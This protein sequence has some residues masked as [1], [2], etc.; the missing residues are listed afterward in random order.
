MS[1]MWPMFIPVVA[2]VLLAVAVA[3]DAATLVPP[4]RGH[5]GITYLGLVTSLLAVAGLLIIALD[6]ALGHIR[7]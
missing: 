2:V 7:P 1:T 6:G 3:L 5:R 4:Q